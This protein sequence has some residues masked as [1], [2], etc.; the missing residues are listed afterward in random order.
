MYFSSTDLMRVF[1]TTRKD[2]EVTAVGTQ[3]RSTEI[4]IAMAASDSKAAESN[5][6]TIKKVDLEEIKMLLAISGVA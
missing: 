5:N 1:M 2:S 4:S 6:K 3:S